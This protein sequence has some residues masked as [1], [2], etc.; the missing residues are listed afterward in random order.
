MVFLRLAQRF[1]L[2]GY[3]I[4]VFSYDAAPIVGATDIHWQHIQLPLSKKYFFP[5]RPWLP[6]SQYIRR[7]QLSKLLV[8][9]YY[10]SSNQYFLLTM[11]WDLQSLLACEVASLLRRPFHLIMHDDEIAFQLSPFHRFLAKIKRSYLVRKAS[12]IFPISHQI[13]SQ[14]PLQYRDKCIL[15]P[16]LP[17]KYQSQVP[18]APPDNSYSPGT[19]KRYTYHLAYAG[20]IYPPM[21]LEIQNLLA[22][23]KELSLRLL[24]ISNISIET[25][26]PFSQYNRN[27]T[28]LPY[29]KSPQESF[30]YLQA[31][32][33]V[34]WVCSPLN[35]AGRWRMLRSSFPSKLA[36]L[37]VNGFP[38]VI[39]TNLN[40]SLYDWG[41]N[42]LADY[43]FTGCYYK[44]LSLFLKKLTPHQRL[45]MSR[46]S[47]DLGASQFDPH[48]LGE[49][50][51]GLVTN[52]R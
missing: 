18:L 29:F 9:T 13:A 52:C 11:P 36:E 45:E 8:A 43:T 23:F 31:H 17:S 46:I 10:S 42:Y 4:R 39:T 37:S 35:L 47:H 34:A 3:R 27:L 16:P 2:H 25:L 24:I 6:F 44:S 33:L 26:D 41:T 51:V 32:V 48:Q 40:S 19:A 21:V 22:Y 49:L 5:V 7:K 50:I 15:F 14:I 28:V 20:K 1:I 30:E 38:F 12:Y